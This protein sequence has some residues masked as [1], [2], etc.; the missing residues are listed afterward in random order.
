MQIY[1]FV[2]DGEEQSIMSSK[3]EIATQLDFRLNIVINIV[4]HAF[5]DRSDPRIRPSSRGMARGQVHPEKPFC[6]SFPDPHCRLAVS[7]DFHAC[8]NGK[9][10]PHARMDVRTHHRKA[11]LMRGDP[12]NMT[13][14]AAR[15]QI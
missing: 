12:I 4:G 15:M 5:Y 1:H 3:I 2:R 10:E 14:A 11:R 13:M 8:A 6:P 9:S 7:L